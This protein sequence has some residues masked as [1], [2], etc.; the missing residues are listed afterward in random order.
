MHYVSIFFLLLSHLVNNNKVA[1]VPN[2]V[3]VQSIIDRRFESAVSNH[4]A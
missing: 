3:R 1:I 2:V 4:Q